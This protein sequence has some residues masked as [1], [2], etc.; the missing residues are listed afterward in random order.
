MIKDADLE[1]AAMK[2]YEDEIQEIIK[3]NKAHIKHGYATN[4][5]QPM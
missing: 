3:S 4:V 5:G 1:D 2:E